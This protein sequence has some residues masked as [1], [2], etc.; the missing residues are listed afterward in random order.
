[1]PGVDPIVMVWLE[2][3]DQKPVIL[4]EPLGISSIEVKILL[5]VGKRD[6]N[7]TIDPV[8]LVLFPR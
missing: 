4:V 8:C 7:T 3:V 2:T 1:M 6:L 5:E